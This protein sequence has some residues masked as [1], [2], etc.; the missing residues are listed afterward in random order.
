MNLLNSLPSETLTRDEENLLAKK[1][2]KGGARAE[3]AANKLA[4]YNM[5]EGFLYAKGV[6]HKIT[7]EGEVFSLTYKALLSSAYR[8][9]PKFG[10]RFFAFS[11]A[12]IRGALKRYWNSLDTVKHASLH[13]LEGDNDE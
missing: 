6:G 12:R 7:D 2:K 8:F 9:D 13:E 1:I 3:D 4:L 10:G 11:K 5:R